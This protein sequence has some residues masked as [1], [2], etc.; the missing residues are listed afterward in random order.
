[1]G[2]GKSQKTVRP[3]LLLLWEG[4]LR[5]GIADGKVQGSHSFCHR[6]SLQLMA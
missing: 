6:F 4:I 3:Y 2:R 5:P 1:M